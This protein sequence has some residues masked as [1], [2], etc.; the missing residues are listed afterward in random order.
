MRVPVPVAPSR[1][2]IPFSGLP[3]AKDIRYSH[4]F[5]LTEAVS[6]RLSAFTTEAPT[7]WRPPAAW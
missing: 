6:D 1:F 3:R 2:F 4:R 5:R 7:P